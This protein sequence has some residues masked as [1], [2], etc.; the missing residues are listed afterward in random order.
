MCNLAVFEAVIWLF[1][2][3]IMFAIFHHFLIKTAYFTP[4]PLSLHDIIILV[5]LLTGYFM[6]NINGKVNRTQRPN[7]V[8]TTRSWLL[9]ISQEIYF[10]TYKT[11]NT[12]KI[13]GILLCCKERAD[14]SRYK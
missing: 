14:Q 1:C 4:M 3:C 6:I 11:L 7:L 13:S 10:E 12:S 8:H 5:P 2:L 9:R